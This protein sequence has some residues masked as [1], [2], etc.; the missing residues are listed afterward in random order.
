MIDLSGVRN[1]KGLG[2][3]ISLPSLSL[4]EAD[5][6]FFHIHPSLCHNL[7]VKP[8]P[9][10]P[11]LP[12]KKSA[13]NFQD[14]TFLF[15]MV[16]LSL[17]L[18]LFCNHR[19]EVLPLPFFHLRRLMDLY[20]LLSAS[21][22]VPTYVVPT[23]TAKMHSKQ[24]QFSLKKRIKEGGKKISSPLLVFIIAASSRR[25]GGEGRGGKLNEGKEEEEE[26]WP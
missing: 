26:A 9:P 15:P 8:P 7:E 5:L 24:K 18:S 20:G 16:S 13:R 2:R 11:C 6:P 21:I 25:R 23:T 10:I 17:S 3:N 14:L 4:F 12:T 19:P 1:L 22:V